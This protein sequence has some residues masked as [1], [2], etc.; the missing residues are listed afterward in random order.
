MET[1]L[2]SRVNISINVN[3]RIDAKKDQ[4]V[5]LAEGN[6]FSAVACN[7]SVLGIAIRVKYFLPKGLV[8]DLEIDGIYFGL[9]GPMKI[10]AEVR[11]CDYVKYRTYECG[12]KFLD[13]TAQYKKAIE[14]FVSAR[15]KKKKKTS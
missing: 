12:L 5:I 2:A 13:I 3:S 6:R 7:I 15:G 1:R 4:Q 14:N 11:H 8:L 10:K 9:E